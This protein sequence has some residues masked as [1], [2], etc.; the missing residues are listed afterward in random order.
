[1]L[2]S[3]AAQAAVSESTPVCRDSV[4]TNYVA[5]APFATSNTR[6]HPQHHTGHNLWVCGGAHRSAVEPPKG[7]SPARLQRS[8]DS[9][10]AARQPAPERAHAG[11]SRTPSHPR[12]PTHHV[13]R[14][15]SGASRPKPMPCC[16][17]HLLLRQEIWPPTPT[18]RR[19][20]A[21]TR[22][23]AAVTRPRTTIC[24]TSP[25]RSRRCVSTAAATT[26][27]PTTL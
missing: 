27:M 6:S 21:R 25:T 8:S 7:S 13:L 23:L 26:Q 17:H 4:A 24:P 5:G 10:S 16:H 14:L 22:S 20:P 9:A 18:M 1:M 12:A 3:R 11:R 15:A 19:G 2:F